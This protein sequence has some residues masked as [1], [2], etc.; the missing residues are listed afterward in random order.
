Q[1][2]TVANAG[3]NQTLC[4]VTSA[5]LAANAPASGTGTWTKVSGPTAVTFTNPNNPNTTVNGLAAG[6]YQFQWTISNGVCASTQSTVQIQVDPQ[7]VPGTLASPATVC[8]T[9]NTGTLTLSG[10]T[11]SI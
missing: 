1:P 4:N 10:Y 7:T 5:T 8:A 9:S 2:V 6:V 3:P 11:S